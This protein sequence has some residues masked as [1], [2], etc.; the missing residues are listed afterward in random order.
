MSDKLIAES[1]RATIRA[2]QKALADTQVER[3]LLADENAELKRTRERLRNDLKR[4]Q[5]LYASAEQEVR[6]LQARVAE[7][8]RIGAMFLD[9][10]AAW[11]DAM[12]AMKAALER[13]DD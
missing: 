3:I 11:V 1:L 2:L 7:L 9:P 5:E 13:S 12:T 8:E 4:E 10:N 6:K